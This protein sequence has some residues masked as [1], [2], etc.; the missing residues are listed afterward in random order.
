MRFDCARDQTSLLSL[1]GWTEHTLELIPNGPLAVA[2]HGRVKC[3]LALD[4]VPV[5][6]HGRCSCLPDL[7]VAPAAHA[8]SAAIPWLSCRLAVLT[9]AARTEV[10]HAEKTSFCVSRIPLVQA[11]LWLPVGQGCFWPTMGNQERR[12][13]C[14]PFWPSAVRR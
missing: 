2:I 5:S 11:G 9:Q 6:R 12:L 3:L 7:S 1:S 8:V 13:S 10:I 14:R 4:A